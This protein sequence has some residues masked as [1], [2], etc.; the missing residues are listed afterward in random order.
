MRSI[1]I[2]ARAVAITAVSSSAGA[3]PVSGD[4]PVVQQRS[5]SCAPRCTVLIN[6]NPNSRIV[7]TLESVPSETWPMYDMAGNRVQ[8]TART[9]PVLL[10]AG[11]ILKLADVL[12][13]EERQTPPMMRREVT[14]TY[15]IAGFYIP[16]P[17]LSDLPAGVPEDFARLYVSWAHDFDGKGACGLDNPEAKILVLTNMNPY[18][19]IAVTYRNLRP[20]QNKNEQT[21]YLEPTETRGIGC[22]SDWPVLTIGEVRFSN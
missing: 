18:R 1:D 20:Y 15:R 3:Q 4:G 9:T 8:L 16:K 5:S 12:V 7:V 17:D 11:Q 10:Q 19:S 2:I 14:F 21:V 6:R 13:T 22:E